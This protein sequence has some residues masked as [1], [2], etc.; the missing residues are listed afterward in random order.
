MQ[1]ATALTLCQ[2]QVH[3]PQYFIHYWIYMKFPLRIWKQQQLHTEVA[4][5]STRE[6]F[7][8]SSESK[9]QN[10][11]TS[12]WLP[13]SILLCLVKTSQHCRASARSTDF[14]K[15]HPGSYCVE[16]MVHSKASMWLTIIV[17]E[18][19]YNYIQVTTMHFLQRES[20]KATCPRPLK[21]Y[22]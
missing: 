6:E 20:Q 12:S 4:H 2:M 18:E 21:R 16:A 10:S 17:P 3:K 8:R 9:P 13:F 5:G 15:I 7:T 22:A 19:S 11:L 1:Q 14:P